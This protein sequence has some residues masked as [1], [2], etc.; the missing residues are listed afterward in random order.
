MVRRVGGPLELGA[1]RPAARDPPPHP[2]LQHPRHLSR[3]DARQRPLPGRG[4][5]EH[6]LPAR[7]GG[8]GPRHPRDRGDRRCRRRR[9]SRRWTTSSCCWRRPAR[10]LERHLQVHRLPDRHPPPRGGLPRAGRAAAR[11]LPGL[12]RRRRGRARAAR[13][14]GRGRRHRRHPAEREGDVL[15]GRPLRGDRRAGDGGDLLQPGR[16][17]PLRARP[18]RRR[19]RR[20]AERHRPAAGTA[21]ARPAGGRC[22]GRR[23]PCRGRWRTPGLRP[24]TGS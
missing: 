8:P 12:H 18:G 14:G 17:S 21:A 9:P 24:S 23:R 13:V 3:A 2:P 22:I 11:R 10:E 5:R 4:G 7:P 19:R 15:A 16:R 1:A 6:G 20:D